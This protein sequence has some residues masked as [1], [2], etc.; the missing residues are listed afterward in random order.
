ME[1]EALGFCPVCQNKL[2]VTKLCCKNCGLELSNEFSLPPISYLSKE[3]RETLEIF[4]ICGGNMK[5]MQEKTGKS[6]PYVKKMLD[7]VFEK[8]GYKPIEEEKE[9]R[10]EDVTKFTVDPESAKASEIVR[11]KLIAGN[12]VAEVESINGNIYTIAI[13]RDGKGFT[14]PALPLIKYEFSVFDVI[15]DLLKGQGGKAYKGNGRN[16]KLG[17]P[18]CE[19]TTV[20]G[21]IGKYYAGK[22]EG[23]SV[24]DPVF[25]MSAILA[26]ANICRNERGY[27]TFTADYRTKMAK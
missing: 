7:N 4:L 12:G 19:I 21:A 5:A 1:T 27:L 15:V 23:D 14:S 6:Y 18:G 20:V 26:W 16:Y 8:L 25:I 24:F 11:S 9:M 10:P 22:N 13:T 3:Q 17:E 2:I